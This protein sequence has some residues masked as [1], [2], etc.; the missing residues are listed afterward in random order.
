MTSAT[1]EAATATTPES[2][3]EPLLIGECEIEP[4]VRFRKVTKGGKHIGNVMALGDEWL[5]MPVRQGTEPIYAATLK[6]VV[7]ALETTAKGRRSERTPAAP[8]DPKV[9]AL[10]ALTLAARYSD[11]AAG[12]VKKIERRWDRFR[13][14]AEYRNASDKVQAAKDALTK[15]AQTLAKQDRLDVA[16]IEFTR[17]TKI[18]EAWAEAV[19]RF[20]QRAA[21]AKAQL[22]Q[23]HAFA[24][25]PDQ[26]ATQAEAD[27]AVS[28]ARKPRQPRK[29]K[30]AAK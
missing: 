23:A 22:A 11:R 5:G 15:G 14:T 18:D 17:L 3:D 28:E 12:D 27:A 7:L 21:T 19:E 4:G 9:A 20:E 10:K 24:Q 2:L 30:A 13:S 1:T 29:P 6:D 8:K 26:G 16:E 25:E